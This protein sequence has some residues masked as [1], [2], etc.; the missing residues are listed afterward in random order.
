MIEIMRRIAI[1]FLWVAVVFLGITVISFWVIHLAPG[2]PTDMVT[3]LNPAADTD[4]RAKFEKLYGL[5]QPLHAQYAQWLG[6]LVK[7]DFGDSISGDRRPV[8]ERIR[9]RL[10]LTFGMNVASMVLTLLI[11]VPL[12]ITAAWWRDGIFDKATTV[13]VFIGFAMPGFWLALLLMLW[14]GIQWPVL[15]I[16]GLTSLSFQ[17]M[18]PWE[19]FIDLAR[20]L[21]LPIFIYTAGSWAGMSRFMRSSM[22]EVLRQD[23]IMTARAKGLSSRTVLFKHALRNAL[24]PVITILGLS[25]PSL[26]GGSVIIESIFAL[27]GLGQLFYGAVM[28]RDYPLIMGSLVLGAVLTL[29]GNLLADVGYGLADPRIR[30]AGRSA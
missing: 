28:A 17:T 30:S 2:S 18:T 24:M 20:H 27:P 29:A 10:P 26:I 12:G 21:I 13:I 5:D 1:K 4:A 3:T 14:L 7:F 15:P 19:K 8:W 11:A 9:E 6:R 22:L 16:S 25:V 23:Y